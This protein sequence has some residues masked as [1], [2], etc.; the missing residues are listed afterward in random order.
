MAFPLPQS[1]RIFQ[2]FVI[3]ACLFHGN[4]FCIFPAGEPGKPCC[5]GQTDFRVEHLGKY[6]LTAH[7]ADTLRQSRSDLIA[8]S[9]FHLDIILQG[10]GFRPMIEC[11][12]NTFS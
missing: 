6:L 11:E 2:I 10:K 1:F 4:I 5:R 3:T 12:W 8:I 9:L 7:R